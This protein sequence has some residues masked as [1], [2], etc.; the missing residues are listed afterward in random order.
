MVTELLKLT[1]KRQENDQEEDD[2]DEDDESEDNPGRRSSF[3]EGPSQTSYDGDDGDQDDAVKEAIALVLREHPLPMST[4]NAELL[5]RLNNISERNK[6][7]SEL[8][9]FEF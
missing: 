9:L 8:I 1:A 2:S 6:V 7:M 3:S 4:L 5:R